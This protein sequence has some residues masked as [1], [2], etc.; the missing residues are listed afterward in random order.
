MDKAIKL[1]LNQILQYHLVYFVFLMEIVNELIE[2]S[3]ILTTVE[4][5]FVKISGRSRWKFLGRVFFGFFF[6]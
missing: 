1:F 3:E 5:G 2:L 4:N 6:H